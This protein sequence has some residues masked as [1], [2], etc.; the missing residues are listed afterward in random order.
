MSSPVQV[1]RSK[2]KI[3]WVI[4]IFAVGVG[5]ILIDHHSTISSYFCVFRGSVWCTMWV[6]CDG[7]VWLHPSPYT[8][9]SR[10]CLQPRH[11]RAWPAA[12]TST[13]QSICRIIFWRWSAA[14]CASQA[15]QDAKTGSQWAVWAIAYLSWVPWCGSRADWCWARSV[16]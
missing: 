10:H 11:L 7:D 2:V 15:D 16:G 4:R 1:N 6:C 8:L 14:R 12:Q 13:H 5:G 9:R 3:T